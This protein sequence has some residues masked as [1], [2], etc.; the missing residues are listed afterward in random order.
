[1]VDVEGVRRAALLTSELRSRGI[2][3]AQVPTALSSSLIRD[4]CTGER[5][6]WDAQKETLTFNGLERPPRGMHEFIS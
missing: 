3:V 6:G 5:F 2:V 4:P 1:M